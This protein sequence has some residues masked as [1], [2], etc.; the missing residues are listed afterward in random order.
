MSMQLTE[1]GAGRLAAVLDTGGGKGGGA[2]GT[3]LSFVVFVVSDHR[4]HVSVTPGH[5]GLY[6]PDAAN[7]F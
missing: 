4:K 7:A 6:G 5:E 2:P 3:A 1:H